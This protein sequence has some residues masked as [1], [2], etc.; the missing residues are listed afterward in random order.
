MDVEPL[1][2]KYASFGWDVL[3]IDGHDMNQIVDALQQAEA[4]RE[5]HAQSSFS[6]TPSKAKASASWRIRPAGTA[7]RRTTTNWSKGLHELGSH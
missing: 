3:R 1:A 7:K 5:G 2:A 6:P 4:F